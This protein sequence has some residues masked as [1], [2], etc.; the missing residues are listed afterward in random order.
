MPLSFP[1]SPTVGQTSSQ[2]GRTYV[3]TGV[4]ELAG[5]VAGHASSHGAA[6]A[7]PITLASSQISDFATAVAAASP[8]PIHPFLLMGG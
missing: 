1:S 5:N 7:D 8:A 6:G 2:N 3:W 4:W